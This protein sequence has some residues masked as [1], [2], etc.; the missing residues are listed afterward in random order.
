M[1][2]NSLLTISNTLGG[3]IFHLGFPKIS[4]FNIY[5]D[6]SP[7]PLALTSK[8]DYEQYLSYRVNYIIDDATFDNI[9]YKKTIRI[10]TPSVT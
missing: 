2:L 10:L 4:E 1:S 5:L 6:D 8:N 9:T 3:L 7:T